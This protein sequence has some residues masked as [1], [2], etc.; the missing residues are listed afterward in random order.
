MNRVVVAET[1][2]GAVLEFKSMHGR[3]ALSE[4][5]A[6]EVELVAETS[7]ITADSVLGKPLTLEIE[8]QN[9]A[10]RHLS[11]DVVRFAYVGHEAGGF[12]LA[13]YRATVCP[14]LWYLTR[15]RDCRIY[16]NKSVVEIL[17]EVLGS[18]SGYAYE[19]KLQGNY[20]TR[21]YC[22]QYEESDFDFI[23]RLMEHEGIYYYFEHG[24]NQHTLVLVDDIGEHEPLPDY[25]SLDYFPQEGNVEEQGIHAWTSEEELRGLEYVVNDYDFK[26]SSLNLQS[27]LKESYSVQQAN[28][29]I[30]EWQ[31]GYVDIQ[32][33]EHYVKVRLEET[34]SASE[35]SSGTSNVRGMAPGHT[36]RLRQ[37]PRKADI[38]EYLLISVE[39]FLTEAGYQ[40][41]E[42]NGEYRLDFTVQPTSL[43]FRAP[44]KTRIPK[45]TGPQTAVVTGPAGSEV[46]TDS[47]QRVKLHFRWD[48][49]SPMD[50]SSSCWV[51]VSNDSAGSG[52][53]A[54]STPRVGQEVVVD[55]IG[56][57]PDR[58]LVTGRVYND[59]QMPAGGFVPSPTMVGFSSRSHYGSPANESHLYIENKLGSEYVKLHSE[60]DLHVVVEGLETRD[61]GQSR[62][63]HIGTFE[64]NTVG[65]YQKNIV[66]SYRDTTVNGY[67]TL[68]VTG[69]D[70]TEDFE[71]RYINDTKSDIEVT[72]ADGHIHIKADTGYGKFEAN[73]IILVKSTGDNNVNVQKGGDDHQL[74]LEGDN[75]ILKAPT[76]VTITAT[77]GN[78]EFWSSG[79]MKIFADAGPL[80]IQRGG[81]G[82]SINMAGD[83][84]TIKAPARITLE[85][86]ELIWNGSAL[87][88]THKSQ[89][90]S[91]IWK[92]EAFVEVFQ[93]RAFHQSAS[94]LRHQLNA[95]QST[96]YVMKSDTGVLKL[97][98]SA[99]KGNNNATDIKLGTFR[100]W[101][102]A[103]M[104]IV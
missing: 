89:F 38:R 83:N 7:A 93:A 46:Y 42:G 36:F 72:S 74:G 97:D 9:G 54:I 64:E 18:Y 20:R 75:A 3:E 86:P 48:R 59:R 67:D 50:E 43:P 68:K 77:G 41:G 57:N 40:S 32:D 30:Y 73:D 69:G 47:Y 103:F 1:A 100:T 82:H 34:R 92:G 21:E 87:K 51:R 56:G 61:V 88:D 2:L 25:P 101:F 10:R 102:Q 12:R 11:G 55:F 14:W 58:P 90:T 4:L 44:M 53:G 62:V 63:T 8:T 95:S 19:K 35:R 79:T 49:Y 84:M 91:G 52:Y 39:Y 66:E 13:R 24:Q 17:D 65:D 71:H 31:G 81:A 98:V 78:G 6:F 96:F 37:S 45:T 85:S 99:F 33:G 80:D 28:H 5:Y 27:R 29:E 22:V 26:K 16:Q 104:L 15:N 60:K 76:D 94:V 23:S 70:R